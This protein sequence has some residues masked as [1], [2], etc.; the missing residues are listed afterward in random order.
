ME[1]LQLSLDVLVTDDLAELALHQ[2]RYTHLRLS[3]VLAWC[4]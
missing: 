3:L 2:L 1:L 4:W